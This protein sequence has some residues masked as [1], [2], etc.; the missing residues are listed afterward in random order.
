MASSRKH[1]D[2]E[3]TNDNIGLEDDK[4]SLVMNSS[5][6]G[7]SEFKQNEL[8]KDIIMQSPSIYTPKVKIEQTHE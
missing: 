7:Y 1:N 3:E 2:L 8:S 4:M 5:H 6:K